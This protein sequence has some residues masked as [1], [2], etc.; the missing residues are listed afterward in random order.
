MNRVCIFKGYSLSPEQSSRSVSPAVGSSA[1]NFG[2]PLSDAARTPP[3]PRLL[4]KVENNVLRQRW[5]GWQ[6]IN[7]DKK[8]DHLR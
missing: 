8:C 1:Q 3:S 5:S 4:C 6:V 7:N 2:A